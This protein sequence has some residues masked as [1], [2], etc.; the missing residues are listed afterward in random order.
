MC[1]FVAWKGC[2][3]WLTFLMC[4]VFVLSNQ[5]QHPFD[6]SVCF[7]LVLKRVSNHLCFSFFPKGREKPSTCMRYVLLQLGSSGSL[8]SSS[9]SSSSLL[10]QSS[11]SSPSSCPKMAR[12]NAYPSEVL[13]CLPSG[14]SSRPLWNRMSGRRC[15][16]QF[17][18]CLKHRNRLTLYSLRALPQLLSSYYWTCVT[19][20]SLILH[21]FRALLYS[22]QLLTSY[23]WTC[24]TN[25]ILT[26][27]SFRAL[28]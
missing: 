7:D 28:S 22:S 16:T 25:S 13:L 23:C 5:Y 3:H 11:G 20:N 14:G 12:K 6:P 18:C 24:V 21:S 4:I 27:Y 19:N 10:S 9:S 2:L 8:S 17:S 1:V 15:C 26:I